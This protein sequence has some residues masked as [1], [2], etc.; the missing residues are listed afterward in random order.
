MADF[1]ILIAGGGPAGALA[2]LLLARA[3]HDVVLAWQ[4]GAAAARPVEVMPPWCLHHLAIHGISLAPFALACRGLLS[5]WDRDAPH[6]HDYELLGGSAGVAFSPNQLEAQLLVQIANS[7]VRQLHGRVKR[8]GGAATGLVLHDAAGPAR[9]LSARLLVWA[10]GRSCQ[11]GAQASRDHFDR[12]VA[13]TFP[14]ITCR[15][16]DCLIVE[17]VAEGWWYVPPSSATASQ[18]VFLSDADLIP[19]GVKA[20]SRF[21][22]AV[23]ARS[24]L[25]R[26]LALEPPAFLMSAGCDARFSANRP[27]A[28]AGWLALGD[29]AVSLDPL[30]GSGVSNAFAAASELAAQLGK[31]PGRSPEA[32]CH[33]LHTWYSSLLERERVMRSRTYAR[34]AHRFPGAPFWVR[35]SVP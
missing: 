27:F 16:C 32:A 23:F 8:Q 18:L 25:V 28:G 12:L 29:A 1:D 24:P 33:A 13:I 14:F 10:T 17:A 20:R 22:R 6:F 19:A 26:S 4:P 9:T 3:G 7:P 15:E 11:A 31:V 34:A 2:A 30:S 5:A 35:R 21:L